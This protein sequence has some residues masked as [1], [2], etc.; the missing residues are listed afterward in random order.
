MKIAQHGAT[1]APITMTLETKEEATLLWDMMLKV[2]RETK[3]AK[4]FEMASAIADWITNE[5]HL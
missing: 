3:D 5:A 1:F 2:K 4:Q